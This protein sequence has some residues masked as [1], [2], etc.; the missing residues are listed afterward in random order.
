MKYFSERHLAMTTRTRNDAYDDEDTL[1][2]GSKC[3]I[4]DS[5]SLDTGLFGAIAH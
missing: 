2:T 4:R 5:S 1:L 3:M